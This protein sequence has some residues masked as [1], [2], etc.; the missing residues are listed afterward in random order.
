MTPRGRA[1]PEARSQL[2]DAAET[3]IRRDG[4][5]GAA[6]GAVA[7]EAGVGDGRQ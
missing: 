7:G 3:V 6:P 5:A 4:L 1:N 2:L